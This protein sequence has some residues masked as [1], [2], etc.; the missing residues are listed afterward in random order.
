MM[1]STPRLADCGNDGRSTS[2]TIIRLERDAFDP[3]NGC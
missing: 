1:R 3:D 2:V